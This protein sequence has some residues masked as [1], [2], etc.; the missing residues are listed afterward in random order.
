MAGAAATVR[1]ANVADMAGE[2]AAAGMAVRACSGEEAGGCPDPLELRQGVGGRR[3]GGAPAR[4]WAQGS[5]AACRRCSKEAAPEE[6]GACSEEAASEE[7]GAARRAEAPAGLAAACGLWSSVRE[8][9]DGTSSVRRREEEG[10]GGA[11]PPPPP[12]HGLHREEGGGR[13]DELNAAAVLLAASGGSGGA[14]G[15]GERGER[16]EEDVDIE[17]EKT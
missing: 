6:G 5:A 4:E 1:I 16:D 8:E 2:V 7:G 3:E 14:C 11:P 12:C 17:D 15:G 9:G 13:W 10:G